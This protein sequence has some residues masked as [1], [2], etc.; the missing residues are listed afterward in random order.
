M[1]LSTLTAL[2]LLS[3]ATTGSAPPP[4]ETPLE[5]FS[6]PV[7]APEERN[8]A[9]AHGLA[10]AMY[11]DDHMT[12][13][14]DVP[15]RRGDLPKDWAPDEKL[16]TLLEDSQWLVRPVLEAALMPHCDFELAYEKGAS[17]LLPHVDRLRRDAKLLLADARRLERAG[18][19]EEAARRIEGVFGLARHF[20]HDGVWISAGSSMDLAMLAA[21]EA[22]RLAPALE[23]AA[24]RALLDQIGL[25]HGLDPFGNR[26][27][28][29]TQVEHTFANSALDIAGAR[30]EQI[31]GFVGVEIPEEP[32]RPS[33][34]AEQEFVDEQVEHCR[35]WA[36]DVLTAWDEDD[37]DARLRD[38]QR[39]LEAGEYGSLAQASPG[40]SATPFW[41]KERTALEQMAAAREAL[42]GEGKAN[43]AE[44]A[45]AP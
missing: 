31:G 19:H 27:A 33:T 7:I 44:T 26:A 30:R 16:S 10:W 12:R 40:I 1:I 28:V 9:I 38:I 14:G 13:L 17:L 45:T 4:V 39:K 25:F 29:V 41:L 35:R 21:E 15:L 37:G 23:P 34:E 32:T 2:A 18:D 3:P 5:A 24:R 6:R 36:A 11:M 43:A 42:G 20:A 22:T 8:A